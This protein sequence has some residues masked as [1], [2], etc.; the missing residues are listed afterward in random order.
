MLTDHIAAFLGECKR[1]G[2]SPR[3]IDFYAYVLSLLNRHL[4]TQPINST[5]VHEFIADMYERELSMYTIRGRI[6]TLKKFF[7]WCVSDE[8]FVTDLGKNLTIPRV[9]DR[10]PRGI[11]I[12]DFRKLFAAALSPRDRAILITL[13]DTGCRAS[14]LCGMRLSNLNL[15]DGIVLVCGKGNQEGF[16]SLSPPTQEVI[17]TWLDVRQSKSDY[18]FTSNTGGEF[19]YITLK[20]MLRRLKHRSGVTG[21]CNAHSFRHG[22][23][24]EYVL[25]GGDLSTLADLL[26][27]RDISTTRIYAVF[28]RAELQRKHQKHS[29]V[30]RL[31]LGTLNLRN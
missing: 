8:R 18:L 20:E 13:L 30:A 5:L 22:F 19:T 28:S 1:A 3:T 15:K 31:G 24:R 25:D 26:R 4:D 17:Q 7:R 21:P 23:A 6:R 9:P 11:S 27:H 10:I 29:P 2:L 16:V 12:P 14:E